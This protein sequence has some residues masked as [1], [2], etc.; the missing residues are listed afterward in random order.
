MIP[1]FGPYRANWSGKDD[2]QKVP[3]K[4]T[5]ELDPG[6]SVTGTVVDQQENPV[7]GVNVRFPMIRYKNRPGDSSRR[8]LSTTLLLAAGRWR[9][10]SVSTPTGRSTRIQSPW[11]HAH[12]LR[13]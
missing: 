10:D 6:W 2:S 8:M 1:G 7:E 5:A 3:A 12:E 9:F 13:F 11:L 4:F